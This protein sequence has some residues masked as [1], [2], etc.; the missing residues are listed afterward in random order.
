[1]VDQLCSHVIRPYPML[2][3]EPLSFLWRFLDRPPKIGKFVTGL[4]EELGT[5]NYIYT[6]CKGE[7][8]YATESRNIITEKMGQ[9][10]L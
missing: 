1:M 2:S 8:G 6:A 5:K 3:P 10:R 9:L 4:S 7:K